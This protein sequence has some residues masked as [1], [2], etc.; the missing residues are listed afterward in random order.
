MTIKLSDCREFLVSILSN[1]RISLDP[2]HFHPA[3]V[4]VL[5]EVFAADRQ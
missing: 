5:K 2:A 4:A 1:V 3:K